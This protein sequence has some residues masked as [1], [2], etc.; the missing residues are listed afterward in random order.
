MT[1]SSQ[2]RV[3]FSPSPSGLGLHIGGARTCL[4][5]WAWAKKTGGKLL[6]RIEDSDIS[7]STVESRKAI[8]DAL[9]W[10]GLDW[11]EGVDVGG[12]HA[13]YVQSERKGIYLEYA[14]KLIEEGKAYR[15]YCS[16]EELTEAREEWTKNNPKVGFKYPGTCR[17]KPYDSSRPYAIRLVAKRDGTT[18]FTDTI[19]GKITT[20]NIEN[21]DWII[22]RADGLPLYNFSCVLDDA[23]MGITLAARGGDHLA[24]TI[25]QLLMYEALGF[26]PP[27]FGHMPLIR[28]KDNEKLSKRHASV[29]VLEYR[30]QGYHPGAL[31]NYLARLGWSKGDNE[32]FSMEKFIELFDWSGCTKKDSKWDPVK[33]AAIN[34]A[35]LKSETLVPTD[36]YIRHLNPFLVQRG[37]IDL[38]PD[39]V[40]SLIPLIRPKAHTYIEAADMIDPFLRSTPQMNPEAQDKFLTDPT[41]KSKLASFSKFLD[42][43]SIDDWK[44]PSLTEYSSEWMLAEKT[45]IKELG[46]SIRV[47]L[48]G[49]TQSPELFATMA[50]LGKST[51]IERLKQCQ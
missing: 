10:L 24:N 7:R 5:N 46:Q 1:T 39:Y 6:V 25:P 31:L 43:I 33:L 18:E 9:R 2:V 38:N 42:G 41:I 21:Q 36:E 29:G 28:G 14:N 27:V 19:F 50:A 35:H 12:E 20:P 32:V 47:A 23:I 49:R 4:F 11:Q 51:T 8:L 16:D 13:P 34:Y 22:I 26:M 45:T 40:R 44:V 3:R 15:C 48:V 17:N 37:L 30:D